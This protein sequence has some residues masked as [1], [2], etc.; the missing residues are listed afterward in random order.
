MTFNEG[1]TGTVP[2]CPVSVII[3]SIDSKDIERIK[4]N[5]THIFLCFLTHHIERPFRD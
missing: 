1:V 3:K 2:L 4:Q 5:F